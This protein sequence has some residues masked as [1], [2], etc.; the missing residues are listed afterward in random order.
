QRLQAAAQGVDQAV[1]RGAQCLVAG[2]FVVAD[3]VRNADDDLIKADATG[4]ADIGCRHENVS[5][6]RYQRPSLPPVHAASQIF[7]PRAAC[8][9]T[10]R[11]V[12]RQ[13]TATLRT[14][15]RSPRSCC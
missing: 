12:P 9:P 14:A 13:R 1:T 6:S 15:W 11:P 4:G 8:R 2:D 7:P 10:L 5:C 3:I